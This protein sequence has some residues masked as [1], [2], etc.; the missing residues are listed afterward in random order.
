MERKLVNGKPS[1]LTVTAK[2]GH[3]FDSPQ[4]MLDKLMGKIS[5]DPLEFAR[6]DTKNQV[7][8]LKDL[9]GLDFSELDA[10]REATYAKRTEVNRLAK[11]ADAQLKE[12]EYHA[13]APSVQQ[14][15]SDLARQLADAQRAKQDLLTDEK[16]LDRV[17]IEIS[18]KQLQMKQ[19]QEE[20]AQLAIEQNELTES[21]NVKKSLVADD[22]LIEKIN[23]DMK[24]IEA[25]NAKV[26]ENLRHVE[27]Q[28]V[29]EAYKAQADELTKKIEWIDDEKKSR[30]SAVQMP[31]DG[32]YFADEG[33]VYNNVPL[34]QCST[35]EQLK[36]SLA[37]AMALNPQVRVLRMKQGSMLD[38]NTMQWLKSIAQEKD[39]Q[40]WVERVGKEPMTIVI[41]DGLVE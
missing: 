12:L 32:L 26:L 22:F 35:A 6:L 11:D 24:N 5:F 36:I 15:A 29:L 27:K 7:K 25:I 30:L 19:L 37:I 9:L 16:S 17:N 20:L 34:A 14:D 18:R 2:D 39:Y 4:T 28:K 23:N 41:E 38:E 3:K 33:V 1:K 10:E 8:A 31:L 21:V 40:V 13:D